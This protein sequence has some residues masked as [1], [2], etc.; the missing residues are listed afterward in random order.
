MAPS[1]SQSTALL[2]T[3]FAATWIAPS[4]PLEQALHSSLTILSLLALW[5]THKRLGNHEFFLIVV[6]LS[7]HSIAA[8]WLY[9][10]V[11]YDDWIQS[12]TRISH[13]PAISGRNCR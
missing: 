11:P 12:L 6:F 2:L 8:R 9:T 1:K 10:N 5:Q 13:K 7:I 3:I 4:W